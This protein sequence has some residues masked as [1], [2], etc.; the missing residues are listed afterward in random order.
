MFLFIHDNIDHQTF[1]VIS[2]IVNRIDYSWI[3]RTA[4]KYS[5]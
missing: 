4:P 1:D 5:Q 3:V 2:R